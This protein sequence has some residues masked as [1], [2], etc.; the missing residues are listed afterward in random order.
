MRRGKRHNG[1]VTMADSLLLKSIHN[2][3]KLFN[4]MVMSIKVRFIVRS[5]P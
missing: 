2:F 4:E 5:T 1:S 3:G